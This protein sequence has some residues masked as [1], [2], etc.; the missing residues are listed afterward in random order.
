MK[1]TPYMWSKM[2]HES[3]GW[4]LEENVWDETN[5]GNSEQ[6]NQN[7]L[8][9]T[10]NI[11]SAVLYSF[12]PRWRSSFS[13]NNAAF[14]MLTLKQ[15]QCPDKSE[16]WPFCSPIQKRKEIQH[17]EDWNDS[18]VDFCEDFPLLN[19]TETLQILF[20]LHW[21]FFNGGGASI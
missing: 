1:L 19:F 10:H 5:N 12:P 13:P 4:N 6:V 3:I 16:Y 20:L 9:S 15:T 2:F 8:T 17:A 18:I 21:R 11:T 14:A 7:M